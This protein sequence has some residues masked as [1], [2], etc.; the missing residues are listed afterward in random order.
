MTVTGALLVL[1]SQVT[2]SLCEIVIHI[3]S[4]HPPA[5]STGQVII[6]TV[7]QYSLTIK[8]Y[9]SMPHTVVDCQY[10]SIATYQLYSMGLSAACS[11]LH[12]QM[13]H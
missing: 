11:P 4:L 9:C 3:I 10:Q 2:I 5:P 12:N 8:D 6:H 13:L 1:H 7:V